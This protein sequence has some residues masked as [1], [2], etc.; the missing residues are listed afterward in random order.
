MAECHSELLRPSGADPLEI[1]THRAPPLAIRTEA[2]FVNPRG[3][4]VNFVDI[5]HVASALPAVAGGD[6][7]G[8]EAVVRR[9]PMS[10]ANVIFGE[11]PS[12]RTYPMLGRA[13][14]PTALERNIARLARVQ[15]I[16]AC[17]S[18]PIAAA[19]PAHTTKKRVLVNRHD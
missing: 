14:A 15:T 7:R 1:A 17:I 4:A 19:T 12:D 8:L 9:S 3:V 16:G 18:L 6:S 10:G 13:S 11:G 5:Y 2:G